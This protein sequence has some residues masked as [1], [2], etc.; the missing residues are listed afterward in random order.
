MDE[1]TGP[2][3]Y[4]IHVR[5][6][7]R[8]AEVKGHQGSRACP[9]GRAGRRQRGRRYRD[10]H[11]VHRNRRWTV[12]GRRED[13]LIELAAMPTSR[14]KNC[15]PKSVAASSRGAWPLSRSRAVQRAL[16]NAFFRSLDLPPWNQLQTL[17]PP[18]RRIWTRTHGCRRGKP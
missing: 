14:T 1:E 7:E 9:Q 6:D 11:N 15:G 8:G 17:N 12:S 2:A 18:S 16:P 5:S 4:R 10:L 13:M 3:A